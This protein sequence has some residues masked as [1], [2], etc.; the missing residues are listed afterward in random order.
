MWTGGT[1]PMFTAANFPL[2]ISPINRP[3]FCVS[4][5]SYLHAG[6]ASSEGLFL[7]TAYRHAP[8]YSWIMY[9]FCG[10]RVWLWP[11]ILLFLYHFCD[12]WASHKLSSSSEHHVR[13]NLILS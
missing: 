5:G 6:A 13:L 7:K 4:D 10:T 3:Q 12:S 11:Y 9:S 2:I 1:D 8:T